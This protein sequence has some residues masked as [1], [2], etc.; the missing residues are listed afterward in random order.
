MCITLPLVDKCTQQA[1]PIG[2]E[3]A[4]PLKKDPPCDM[5]D[6]RKNSKSIV[7]FKSRGVK[8]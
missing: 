5:H 6:S 7:N 8:M 3:T 2:T 4:T 1:P